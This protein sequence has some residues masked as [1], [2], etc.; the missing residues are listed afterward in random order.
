MKRKHLSFLIPIIILAACAGAPKSDNG[1]VFDPASGTSGSLTMPDGQTV[2]YT[3]YEKLFF[4]T[5]VE[6]NTYQYMNVYVPE[7]A[8]QKT[9]IFLRT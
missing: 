2:S 5:N 3:A 1:L 6:D 8:T 4:V 7:G 9:P